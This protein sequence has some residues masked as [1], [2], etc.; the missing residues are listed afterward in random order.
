MTNTL[1]TSIVY[2]GW[3]PGMY[4]ISM[5][6]DSIKTKLPLCHVSGGYTPPDRLGITYMAEETRHEVC[7]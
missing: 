5:P 3:Q 4:L 7:I 1:H 6:L 2:Y